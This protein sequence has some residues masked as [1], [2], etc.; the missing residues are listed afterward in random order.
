MDIGNIN[1]TNSI[2]TEYNTTKTKARKDVTGFSEHMEEASKVSENKTAVLHGTDKE[3]GDVAVFSAAEVVSGSSITVYKPHDFNPE[4]PIYKVKVWDKAG[5]VTEK[6]IDVSKVDPKNCDTIEMYA[7]S[8][9][10]K[11]TGKGSFEN[12]MLK[13][14]VAKHFLDDENNLGTF[15]FSRKTNW[16]DIARK[17]TQSVFDYGDMK[18]YM[19]WK[20]FLDLLD[21]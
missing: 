20:K 16:V 9:N 4:N 15:D 8:A 6:L 5:N 7:Y 18:G 13:T 14:A 21:K 12:T 11:E 3:T 19:E 2:I 10:L 17:I 1:N